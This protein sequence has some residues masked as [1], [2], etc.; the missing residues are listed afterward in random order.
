MK[1]TP[2][3][4][5]IP[6]IVLLVA[7]IVVF[8]HAKDRSNRQITIG[9]LFNLS[10]YAAFA[11]EDSR[12]GFTM[13][14]EDAHLSSEEVNTVIEDGGSDLKQ[15]VSAATKLTQIDKAVAVIGPEWTEFGEVAA[16]I[17]VRSKVPFISPWIVAEAPY[18]KPPYY[19]SGTPSDRSEH[20][21][22]T[23]YLSTHG[24]T[25]IAVVY[26]NNFWSKLNMQMFKEEATKRSNLTFISEDQV[27]QDTKD[28]RTV[29]AKIKSEKPDA[30]YVAIAEDEGHGAF[31]SQVRQLGLTL[32]VA[33]HSARATSL[34]MKE[35]YPSVLYGQLFARQLPSSRAGEFES[36]YEKRFGR[37]VETPSAAAAY[38]MTTIVLNAVRSGARTSDQVISYL[39]HLT[40]YEGYSGPIAF[41]AQGRLPIRETVMMEYDAQGVAQE[42]K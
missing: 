31:V 39:E 28:F 18:I 13:A 10:G 6:V 33:S 12:N 7:G 21:A 26:S 5:L 42:V 36:K 4:Y 23:G 29:I 14:L 30:I 15:V 2:N 16:P 25:K 35:K 24:L 37:K 32:P 11:G 22:V 17:A 34:V 8:M 19:W 38:D 1:Y 9:G 41:D 27:D 40:P 20:I 3:K